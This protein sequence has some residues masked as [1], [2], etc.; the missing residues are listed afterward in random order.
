MFWVKRVSIYIY[1]TMYVRQIYNIYI[2][3]Y[4]KSTVQL[5]SV[6]LAQD[7]PNKCSIAIHNCHI[8]RITGNFRGRKLVNLWKIRYSLRENFHG[9]LAFGVPQNFF[10]KTFENNHKT[11]KFAKVF[12]LK[13]FLHA[14]WYPCRLRDC[15]TNY[16]LCFMSQLYNSTASINI[17]H[18]RIH[19]TCIYT[20]QSS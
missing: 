7:R 14:I 6:G 1:G 5:A 17:R 20:T 9:L 3:I 8:Y 19:Y 13:S 18:C 12:Y 4:E 11:V 2:Y 10:E 16:C 15:Y